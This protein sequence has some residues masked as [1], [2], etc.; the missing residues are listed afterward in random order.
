MSNDPLQAFLGG[1]SIDDVMSSM[2]TQDR[3][4]SVASQPGYN[5]PS[6]PSSQEN[7]KGGILEGFL[8]SDEE[9]PESE[10]P[11]AAEA[12]E[13]AEQAEASSEGDKE[14]LWVRDHSGKKKKLVIDYNDRESIKKAYKYMAGARKWHAERDA[15]INE[16]KGY[17]ES[18]KEDLDVSLMLQDAY[19]KKGIDG[20]IEAVGGQGAVEKYLEQ[21]SHERRIWEEATPSEREAILARKEAEKAKEGESKYEKRLR[22]LEEKLASKDVEYEEKQM[23]AHLDAAF[24]KYSFAGSIKDAEQAAELD[25]LL[26]MKTI[27]NLNEYPDDVPITRSLV[28]KEMRKSAALLRKFIKEEGSKQA[29]KVVAKQRRKAAESIQ[30]KTKAG[31]VSSSNASKDKKEFMSALNGGSIKNAIQMWVSNKNVRS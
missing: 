20:L 10:E 9:A 27:K 7:E 25:D 2:G 16:L 29:S 18:I 26:W 13:E 21:K 4:P 24:G 3:L 15:A 6:A 23:Q 19:E 14:E 1:A 28:D 22:E 8:S 31:L 17:K 12:P 5:P 11:E 30:N